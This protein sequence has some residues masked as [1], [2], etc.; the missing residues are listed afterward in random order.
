MA[1]W[2][3]NF[4]GVVDAELLQFIWWEWR[5]APPV[6]SIL[7]DRRAGGFPKLLPLLCPIFTGYPGTRCIRAALS[8]DAAISLLATAIQGWDSLHGSLY[9]ADHR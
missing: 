9:R 7:C 3:I 4:D 2:L 5:A 6:S 1:M 8:T